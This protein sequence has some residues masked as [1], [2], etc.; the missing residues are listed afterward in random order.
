MK[1]KLYKSGLTLIELIISLAILGI[2]VI[3][4]VPIFSGGFISICASG[5]ETNAMSQA[6]KYVDKVWKAG[7]VKDINT[8]DEIKNTLGPDNYCS[9]MSKLYLY[10]G[11]DLK[12]NYI[13]NENIEGSSYVKITVVVFYQSGKRNVS[14]TSL[15]PIGGI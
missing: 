6:Q 7:E 14:L 3:S 1:K 12:Y 5:N 2:L 13:T 15:I 8:A 9:D 10:E 4:F 11:K